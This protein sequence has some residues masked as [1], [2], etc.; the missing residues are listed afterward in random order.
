MASRR[1]R[2]L[3]ADDHPGIVKSLSRLLAFDCD[4]VGSVA[5]FRALAEA[6]RRLG[7][8]VIVLDLSLPNA[9]G[10]AAC[11]QLTQDAPGL[12]VIVFTAADDPEVRQ[13]AFDAGA[14]AFVHKLAV[15]GDLLSAVRRLGA[16]IDPAA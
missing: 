8:D 11:R 3:I 1:L 9:G 15:G 7:P 14:A 5:D 4:V 10:L 2:V 6:T 16:A 13:R 12:K